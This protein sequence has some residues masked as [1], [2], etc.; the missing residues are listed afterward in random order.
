M[1]DPYTAS[2]GK[3]PNPIVINRKDVDEQGRSIAC[4]LHPFPG[5]TGCLT[6]P[7]ATALPPQMRWNGVAHY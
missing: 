3:R 6:S 5:P 7:G 1:A 4:I 2:S